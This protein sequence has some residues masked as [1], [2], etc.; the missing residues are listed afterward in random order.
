MT[1]KCNQGEEDLEYYIQEAGE[2]LG[3]LP[4]LKNQE[5]SAKNILF[6]IFKKIVNYKKSDGGRAEAGRLNYVLC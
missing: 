5:K 3:I 4:E 1:N 6:H 2:I